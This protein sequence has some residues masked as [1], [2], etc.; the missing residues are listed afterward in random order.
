MPFVL[1]PPGEVVSL[2]DQL[3]SI[4]WARRSATVA[5]GIF[6]SVA[7]LATTVGLMGILDA[8]IH[9]HPVVRAIGFLAILI[10][11]GAMFLRGVWLPIR[12]PMRPLG[13]AM[14]L[15]DRFPRLNDALASAVEF[16]GTE[17]VPG[18]ERFRKVATARA[19][20]ALE[21]CDTRVVVPS[22]AA[23]RAFGL[24][25]LAI[26]ILVPIGLFNTEHTKVALLRLADPYGEHFWPTRTKLELLEP[27][28]YPARLA[29]GDAFD[30][31]MKLG[32]VLPDQVIVSIRFENGGNW[33]EIVPVPEGN[34]NVECSAKLDASR[35]PRDFQF[36]VRA[37]DAVT[38]WLD[39][40]VA[41]PPKLVPL[42][43]R[44]SPQ[45]SVRY[46]AYTRLPPAIL[47]DGSTVIEAVAGSRIRFR[48]A[49]DRP[50]M[51]AVFVPQQDRK[52][53]KFAP[54]LAS[55]AVGNAFAACANAEL[56]SSGTADIPVAISGSDA[57]LLSAEFTPAFSG[58]YSLRFTDRSGITG[59]R[60]FDFRMLTDPVPAV[61]LEVPPPNGEPQLLL[62]SATITL[63]ARAEDRIYAV[64]RMYLEYRLGGDTAPWQ[65]WNLN[66]PYQLAEALPALL[67]SAVPPLDPQFNT[68][69]G[70][71]TFSLARF[72]GTD[73]AAPVAGDRLTLRVAAF[74]FDDVTAMKPPGR[75]REMEIRIVSAANL[76]SVLLRQLAAMRPPVL[77]LRE[78]QRRAREAVEEFAK[79]PTHESSA[80]LA[81]T[82]REQQAIRNSVADPRDGMKSKAFQ[83]LDLIRKNGLPKSPTTER[84]E[85]VAEE[86]AKLGEQTL[87]SIEPRIAA[88]R[89]AAENGQPGSPEVSKAIEQQ[90][91][92]EKAFDN[93]LT[94]L[95]QWGGAGESRAEAM[96]LREALNKLTEEGKR[97]A[98]KVPPGK[99]AEALTPQEKAA[100]A[101]PAEKMNRLAERIANALG[102][103]ERQAAEKEAAAAKVPGTPE[104]ENAAK[105]AK[106]L[107]EAIQ[108]AGGQQLIEDVRNAA[109]QLGNNST[110]KSAEAAQ[111]AKEKLD[112]FAEALGEKK[113]DIGDAL[114]KKKAAADALDKLA[115][116]QD[117]LAK[118][119]KA[120]A[121]N[122]D[123]LMKLAREQE[124]IRKKVEAAAEKLERLGENTAAEQLRKS[125]EKMAA[126]QEALEGGMPP[127]DEQN[128]ALDRLEEA[129]NK[130]DT[131]R[132][133]NEATLA[134]EKAEEFAAQLKAIREK[135]AAADAEAARLQAEVLKQMG[136]D[137]G[138]LASL[139]D[140]DERIGTVAGELRKFAEKNFE[141]LPVFKQLA[142]QSV[143]SAERSAKRFA[144]RKLDALDAIGETHDAKLEAIAD[145]R[146]RRPLKTAIRRIDHIL[147]ALKEDAKKEQ[148][149][150][151]PPMPAM[152]PEGEPMPKPMGE[153]PAPPTA[154]IKAL[155]ALQ[156]ELNERTAAFAKAHPDRMKLNETD[157][158]ELEELERSQ[159]EVAELFQKLAPAFQMKPAPEIP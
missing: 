18:S 39:V 114:E 49:T 43:S 2:P 48:A 98:E 59:T 77:K 133:K 122:P 159:R 129:V 64:K 40:R 85:A 9:L 121:N 56:V 104:E 144:E 33:E 155:R 62:P 88:A 141:P 75:S 151:E 93:I 97:A 41:E 81:A 117:Q 109:K 124:A 76:E 116:E 139:G 25:A 83:L 87:E 115:E 158:E 23:W 86:L 58:L 107:R 26:T 42:E 147:E 126:A 135:F 73:G 53:W 36:Q 71:G 13:I 89:R 4:A 90:R 50:I 63:D 111:A 14:L 102:K 37:N 44:P 47:P 112:R 152:P 70:G 12:K 74:D 38:A 21:K 57:T 149:K 24:A 103:A 156:V 8:A 28:Q 80:K 67:G 101:A 127:A 82:E 17:P 46:P 34:G 99:P 6:R 5:G 131:E 146:S 3:K 7:I 69:T 79:S 143:E 54:A 134:K 120:A 136:W 15:E 95:E 130:L 19:S 140:M 125:A 1:R 150:A 84:V 138:K 145:D 91:N 31:K 110:A 96:A 60:L 16:H 142:E 132:E 55:L 154:Q 22:G 108:Q 119:T 128:Q 72:A 123:E 78:D 100:L 118:K 29:K 106:A 27:S 61:V 65:D 51:S 20:V 45:M 10:A 11:V 105:E 148:P 52:P 66:D 92:A 68:L 113:P 32:G 137:R 30:L 94:K 157:R 153:Q 35:I